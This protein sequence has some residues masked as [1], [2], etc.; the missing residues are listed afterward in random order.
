M[1]H[2]VSILNEDLQLRAAIASILS[3]ETPG[4]KGWTPV[5]KVGEGQLLKVHSQYFLL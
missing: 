4:H 1:W 5:R 3:M 2:H